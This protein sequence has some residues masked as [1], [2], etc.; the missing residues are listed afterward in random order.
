MLSVLARLLDDLAGQEVTHAMR[1][2]RNAHLLE[3]S[4]SD[5]LIG[6]QRLQTYAEAA[7]ARAETLTKCCNRLGGRAKSRAKLPGKTLEWLDTDAI[8]SQELVE[9]LSAANAFAALERYTGELDSRTS[10]M[11]HLLHAQREAELAEIARLLDCH[12]AGG[13]LAAAA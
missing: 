10:A 5:N 3:L 13:D 11:L 2:R 12:R 8:L 4:G 7:T 1:M 9:A 6:T